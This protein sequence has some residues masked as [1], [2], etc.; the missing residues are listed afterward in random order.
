MAHAEPDM[1][2]Q[3]TTIAPPSSGEEAAAIVAALERFAADTA[4]GRP[5]D[6]VARD[7]WQRTA[8]LEGIRRMGTPVAPT[9]WMN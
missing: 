3:I 2:A 1:P 4:T 6:E 8:L 5:P 7:P 9:T